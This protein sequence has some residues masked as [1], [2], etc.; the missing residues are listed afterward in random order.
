MPCGSM[1]G[2]WPMP[3]RAMGKKPLKSK[4]AFKA[5][6]SAFPDKHDFGFTAVAAIIPFVDASLK[7][8]ILQ[9][10]GNNAGA[11]EVLSQAAL[12]Q[13]KWAA[14]WYFPLREELGRLLIEAGKYPE[15]E[16]VYRQVLKRL[17]L[18][19]R[20]LFGLM[21]ALKVQGKTSDLYWVRQQFQKAWL[22]SDMDIQKL[23]SKK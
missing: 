15:A 3:I 16:I 9:D 7:A 13:D 19:G 21:E 5:K 10:K 12:E 14:D 18:N 20:S 11:S 22:Y 23:F 8:Q 4:N 6:S 17:P 1:E 2:P